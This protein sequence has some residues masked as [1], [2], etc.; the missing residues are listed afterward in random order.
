MPFTDLLLELGG[1]IDR[2]IDIPPEARLCAGKCIGDLHE[3]NISHDEHVHVA[4]ASQLPARRGA[5]DEGDDDV[6]SEGNEGLADDVHETRRL[7]QERLKIAE[8]GRVAVG[9]EV[10]LASL[11]RP[12]EEARFGELP[13]LALNGAV[14][15]P[16]LPDELA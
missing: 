11:D 7:E 13:E 12:H 5:E 4:A 16:T 3:R 6:V 14:R 8:H 2:G 10:H 9:L 1:G 15:T